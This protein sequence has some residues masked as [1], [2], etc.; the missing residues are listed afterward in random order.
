MCLRQDVCE[1][2]RSIGG[3]TLNLDQ[4]IPAEH[5]YLQHVETGPQSRKQQLH[6]SPRRIQ[7]SE[8]RVQDRKVDIRTLG[9]ALAAPFSIKAWWRDIPLPYPWSLEVQYSLSATDLAFWGICLAKPALLIRS[10]L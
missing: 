8:D 7:N 9:S 2:R 4:I 10:Q 1:K 3:C 5:E 6:L